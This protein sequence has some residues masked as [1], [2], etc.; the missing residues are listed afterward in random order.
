MS[1]FF[2]PRLATIFAIA[3]A[4]VTSDAY[5]V[6]RFVARQPAVAVT[7]TPNYRTI[8]PG[9]K[10]Q[11]SAMVTGGGNTSVTWQ[12][13]N[14]VGGTATVGTITK[15]GRF[16]APASI[17]SPAIVNVTAVSQAQP[18]VSATATLTV[19]TQAATGST[20]Y[21]AIT[22]SDSNNG[23]LT[24]PWQHI[25]YAAN[26][27]HAGDTV[28]VRGGIYNELVSFPASGSAA[29]GFIT[30]S[31]YP[32]ELATL[33]GTGLGIPGGQWGLFTI[34]DQSYLVINGFEVRNYKTD[35]KADVPIGIYVSGAGSNVQ[36]IN[37]HIHD[38]VTT[39]TGCGADAFG[40]TVYGT[41]AP[42]SINNIA[43]SGNELDNLVLG[44]SET[45]SLDGN[46]TN[47][48]VT[49]NVVHDNNNIAIGAIGFEKV[50]PQPA[51]DQARNGEIRGNT[52]YNIS[53]YGNPAYGK[54][55]AADGIYV[56]GGTLITIEQNLI[57][58]VDLGIE[59]ASE[60]HNRYTTYVTARNN[61]IYDGNSAGISI[62]GYA[63]GVGGTQNCTVVNNTLFGNDTKNT[64][65]G[66][67]QI[68]FHASSNVFENNILY[69]TTQ[70][71]LLNGFVKSQT[72]PVTIDY[73]LYYSTIGDARA[74]W[75]YQG[76]TYQGY[77]NYLTQTGN[78]SHSPAFS[79]PLFV[80][81]DGT[82]FDLQSGSPASGA[83]DNL[84]P[85]VVGNVDF[86]GNPRMRN[87]LINLGAYE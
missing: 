8:L 56:D 27:V 41:K 72:T 74:S 77:A 22:G 23:S 81:I 53:S 40:L 59:L 39:A 38:I 11:F 82:N 43:I 57:H 48:A 32:G 7:I 17:P 20:Y 31:S 16:T 9:Q 80:A 3:A 61:V 33:D 73:N 21:V 84:G 79:D 36:I 66:E 86:N 37:N 18:T 45:L 68:Q 5:A 54:Q 70:G 24:A 30:F 85:D 10:I 51:Y 58:N 64:G 19:V 4:I 12:V 87:G 2:S 42:D 50:A 46:V 75:N 28:Y 76:K 26:Q 6:P 83:G 25:Q 69:A 35:S 63:G 52:V 55:Y 62:G 78:D 1:F 13:N 49:S 71:L 34:V 60:H 47:F 15:K 44:C 65:S 14:I 67:F 29:A